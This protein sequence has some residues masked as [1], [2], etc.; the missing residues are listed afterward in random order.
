MQPTSSSRI[1]IASND[2]S[3]ALRRV[4]ADARSAAARSVLPSHHGRRRLVALVAGDAEYLERV[5]E[6]RARRRQIVGIQRDLAAH[7]LALALDLAVLHFTRDGVALPE[8]VFRLGVVADI[9]RDLSEVEKADRLADA[10]AERTEDR[11]RLE[12][13]DARPVRVA[14]TQLDERQRRQRGGDV[15]R[16]VDAAAHVEARLE[17]LHR[18]RCSRCD[19]PRAPRRRTARAPA[20]RSTPAPRAVPAPWRRDSRASPT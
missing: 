12:L 9:G 15:D 10:V 5:G 18:G 20:P 13:V 7:P 17:R 16:A 11:Q 6:S 1:S 8:A 14:E 4:R 3:A 2:R 19:S